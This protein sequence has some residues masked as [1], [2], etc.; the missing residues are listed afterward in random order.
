MRRY[1]IPWLGAICLLIGPS[2]V[3]SQTFLTYHCSDGAAF[4]VAFV[5]GSRAAHLQLD[6]KAVSLP[7]RFS[8]SGSRYAK[9]DVTL[10]ITKT[11]TTLR[12]GKRLSECAAT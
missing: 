9:G 5:E 3:F 11:V 4:V 7:R 6:G 8:L 12:R 10:R 1:F 2:P